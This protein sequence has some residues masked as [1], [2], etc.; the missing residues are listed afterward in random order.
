MTNM[1]STL[2]TNAEQAALWNGFAG[3][4]WVDSH[5][6]MN[7]MFKPFE[8]LLVEHARALSPKRVLDM[9][10]GTGGTTLALCRAL[11]GQAAASASISRNP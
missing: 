7:H 4:G 6:L 9:G 1:H 11:G 8:D 5:D 10:C 2:T 3:R